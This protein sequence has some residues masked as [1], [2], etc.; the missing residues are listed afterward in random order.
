VKRV[1]LA[2][3]D[4]DFFGLIFP[5]SEGALWTSQVGGT[6]NGHPEVPGIFVPL[7]MNLPDQG[8]DPLRNHYVTGRGSKDYPRH[9]VEAF[10]NSEEWLEDYF[11][12]LDSWD[13]L[14]MCVPWVVAEAWVPVRVRR[15][16]LG[17]S[18]GARDLLLPFSGQVVILVYTNSD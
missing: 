10:L 5:M 8:D 6:A 11:E 9:L 14:P 18:A 17:E 1:D 3:I 7:P 15:M 2:C 12:P 4:E 13:D 16:P